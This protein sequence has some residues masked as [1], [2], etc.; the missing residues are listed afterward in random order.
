MGRVRVVLMRRLDWG[1]VLA[2]LGVSGLGCSP[3]PD[4]GTVVEAA[5][6]I[7]GMPGGDEGVT[8]K[9]ALPI[10]GGTLAISDAGIAVAS[11]PDRDRV[12]LVDLATERVTPIDT[13]PRAEPGR[14]VIDAS[15]RAHIALRAAGE[16]LSID[17]SQRAVL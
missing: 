10:S 15:G 5:P 8:A 9:Q 6:G 13:P 4:E 1:V 7:S 3:H 16:V 11:D 14:V 12:F 2:C 17:L